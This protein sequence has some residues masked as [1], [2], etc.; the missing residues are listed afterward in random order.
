MSPGL[1]GFKEWPV[2]RDHLLWARNFLSLGLA[3][4]ER[5]ILYLWVEQILGPPWMLPGLMVIK[6]CVN[7]TFF[8]PSMFGQADH[9]HL[10]A[11]AERGCLRS[12]Y[13]LHPNSSIISRGGRGWTVC[14]I[15]N[16][17]IWFPNATSS[18]L[19]CLRKTE[20][21]SP[22]DILLPFVWGSL[23]TDWRSFTLRFLT[24]REIGV[25]LCHD[26]KMTLGS[27]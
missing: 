19:V 17:S 16:T 1:L 4:I 2:L 25:V 22:W 13:D 5:G 20:W 14:Q 26:K 27:C 9:W 8:T 7:P 6:A 15:D 23:R 24:G 3:N 10:H 12:K 18:A 11:C 21:K